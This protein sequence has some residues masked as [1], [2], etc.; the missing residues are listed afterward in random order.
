MDWM[1]SE[2]LRG[3][4]KL[5]GSLVLFT[6]ATPAGKSSCNVMG[7]DRGPVDLVCCASGAVF[8]D[9]SEMALTDAD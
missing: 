1:L 9:A 6:P 4:P 5:A 3:M 2:S 8:G 7:I